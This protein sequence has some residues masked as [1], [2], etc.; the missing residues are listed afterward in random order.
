MADLPAEVV[1]FRDALIRDPQHELAEVAIKLIQETPDLVAMWNA[2]E[3]RED[4]RDPWVWIAL[5]AA[6]EASS[7]PQYHYQSKADRHKLIELVNR[8]STQLSQMLKD[9]DLDAH[10]IHLDPILW[11]GFYFFEDFGKFNRARIDAEEVNKVE[12]TKLLSSIAK[13]CEQKIE[14]EP[15]KGGKAGRNVKAIRFARIM[16]ARHERLYGQPLNHSV[17]A[18]TNAMFDTRYDDSDMRKLISR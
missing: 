11:N 6:K 2:Y 15:P 5:E 8:L 4:G 16:L 10:L 12:F 3:C 18:A 7:L 9:N 1:R 17:A 13:R 14:T